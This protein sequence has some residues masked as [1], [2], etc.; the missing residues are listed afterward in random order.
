MVSDSSLVLISSFVNSTPL[1]QEEVSSSFS[2]GDV[3]V[4]PAS[5]SPK[6]A[7]NNGRGVLECAYSLPAL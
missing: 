3:E 6:R 4:M 7:A 5:Y 2:A 1:E